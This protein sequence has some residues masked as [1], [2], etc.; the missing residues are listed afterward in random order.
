[1]STRYAVKE[2]PRVESRDTLNGEEK[3]P[4]SLADTWFAIEDTANGGNLDGRYEKKETADAECER[5]N[6]RF[7]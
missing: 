3:L 4:N 2:V 1:M 6:D 5:L 7:I